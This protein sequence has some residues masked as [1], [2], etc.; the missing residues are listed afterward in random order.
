MV[1]T[2]LWRLT[3]YST[4][5]RYQL[6]Q[7]VHM[8]HPAC[9]CHSEGGLL[10]VALARVG[11]L[12]GWCCGRNVCHDG[13]T[14]QGRP[15]EHYV[16]MVCQQ[17]AGDAGL[18]GID[19]NLVHDSMASA[20]AAGLHLR[21]SLA[22]HQT[23]AECTAAASCSAAWSASRKLPCHSLRL[24]LCHRTPCA[25]LGLPQLWLTFQGSKQTAGS[26]TNSRGKSTP[27]V[28]SDC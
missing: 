20:A 27:T 14:K 26:S 19:V 7:L 28:W 5:H 18:H 15:H 13:V 4:R 17:E 3:V 21:A 23:P 22:V 24:Q 10:A 16:M 2:S 8:S 11:D 6:R 25:L 1:S 12:P 9:T